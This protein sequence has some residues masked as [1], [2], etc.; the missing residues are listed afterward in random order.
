M[1]VRTRADGAQKEFRRSGIAATCASD[2]PARKHLSE[3]LVKHLS[4]HL[5]KHLSEH[6]VK[7]LSQHLK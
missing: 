1:I 3:H 6:L 7:H 5:V 4:E 2:V